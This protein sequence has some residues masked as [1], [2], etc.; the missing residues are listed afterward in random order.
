[1]NSNSGLCV[2]A[3]SVIDMISAMKSKNQRLIFVRHAKTDNFFCTDLKKDNSIDTSLTVEGEAQARSM[4][5]WYVNI[6]NDAH[7]NEQN[8]VIV[9]SP[10]ART[11][12]TAQLAC[13][14]E[15]S[16]LI[17]NNNL[18]ERV[19]NALHGKEKVFAEIMKIY[20]HDRQNPVRRSEDG[21]ECQ[22]EMLFRMLKFV[23][24]MLTNHENSVIV[25]FSH[26]N[27]I[28]QLLS[29]LSGHPLHT[30]GQ[31][32]ISIGETSCHE[33]LHIPDNMDK[34]LTIINQISQ[35]VPNVMTLF[36]NAS[37]EPI[38]VAKLCI[39]NDILVWALGSYSYSMWWITVPNS[40]K[41]AFCA[42]LA[43]ASSKYNVVT[44]GYIEE[45]DQNN[46][47]YVLIVGQPRRAGLPLQQK[48]DAEIIVA[49]LTREI[50]NII[51]EEQ[52]NSAKNEYQA[53]C[54]LDGNRMYSVEEAV[55]IYGLPYVVGTIYSFNPA[56]ANTSKANF[57]HYI[58]PAIVNRENL[59]NK[60]A[61]DDFASAICKGAI[62]TH[63]A[64][65]AIENNGK[66]INIEFIYL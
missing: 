49:F 37:N 30:I 7:A 27:P 45:F 66:I 19:N 54:G 26:Y 65:V 62:A 41:Q 2:V 47:K 6:E 33:I 18:R 3:Y 28:E 32:G 21:W 53:V 46:F 52:N 40:S 58:E 11:R 34:C 57:G 39:Q 16:K 12:R 42:G 50:D 35:L 23:Q 63:Q 29:F 31:T 36:D 51:I 8:M 9:S 64:R 55:Q 60:W 1:M 5:S 25:A 13:C 38:P 44:T 14:V 17:I 20:E 15:N 61:V 22:V 43:F 59:E 10:F 4:Y 48:R 56:Y 24:E